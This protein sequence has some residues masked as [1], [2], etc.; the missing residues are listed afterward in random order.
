MGDI[1]GSAWLAYS[2][3]QRQATIMLRR[4]ARLKTKEEKQHAQLI[5]S[6]L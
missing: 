5:G 2:R 3:R 1:D 4:F 6:S